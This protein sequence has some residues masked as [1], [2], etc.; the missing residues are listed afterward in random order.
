L[1]KGSAGTLR[2][3]WGELVIGFVGIEVVFSFIALVGLLLGGAACLV[4][5]FGVHSIN[6]FWCMGMIAVSWVALL[7]VLVVVGSVV[8]PLYRCALYIYATEGVVPGPFNKE[9]L[10]TAWKVK[11]H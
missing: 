11:K 8:N 10:D 2:R 7:M 3:A 6:S 9:L 5:S 1:L 4:L